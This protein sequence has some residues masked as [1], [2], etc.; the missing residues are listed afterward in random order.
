[1]IAGMPFDTVHEALSWFCNRPWER[2]GNYARSNFPDGERVQSS[3]WQVS[4]EQVA[5]AF[6]AVRAALDTLLTAREIAIVG[7]HYRRRGATQ[8]DVALY[9]G[10]TDRGIRFVRDRVVNRLEPEFI[11]VGIVRPPQW[12][13]P[14]YARDEGEGAV[15]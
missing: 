9:H 10:L 8:A 13:E 1:M 3:P 11:R 6:L 7:E 5:R 12:G 4:V 15:D 14:V 2:T